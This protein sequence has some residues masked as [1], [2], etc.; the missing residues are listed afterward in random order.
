MVIHHSSLC[1]RSSSIIDNPS[2]DHRRP[3]PMF[4]RL[5]LRAQVIRIA[6][7]LSSDSDGHALPDG[8][9]CLSM[10]IALL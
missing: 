10:N 2:G 5:H 3:L 7:R 6:S 9:V 1:S 8:S 4:C